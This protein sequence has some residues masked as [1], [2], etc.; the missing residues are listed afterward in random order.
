[1]VQVGK[2][3]IDG[4]YGKGIVII[5]AHLPAKRIPILGCPLYQCWLVAACTRPV[6]VGKK[7]Q[8]SLLGRIFHVQQG[9]ITAK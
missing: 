7:L 9:D 3:T 6:Q 4:S 1:M 5:L 2:Y 8:T